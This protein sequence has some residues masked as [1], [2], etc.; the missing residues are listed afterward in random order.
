[1]GQG[2]QGGS[3]MSVAEFFHMGG[4]G[5]Y[6]WMS[7]G[8]TFLLMFLEII[9]LR[10]KRKTVLRQIGRMIRINKQEVSGE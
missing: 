10:S 4:F 3:V 6:V 8:M 2:S 5:F 1:M 9:M 7:M